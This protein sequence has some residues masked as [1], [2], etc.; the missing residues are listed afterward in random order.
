MVQ[1]RFRGHACNVFIINMFVSGPSCGYSGSG[2]LDT[3]EL[4]PKMN[5]EL[6][7]KS[8]RDGSMPLSK[9]YAIKK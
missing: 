2:E 6:D 5:R 4:E 3:A 9:Y 1:V 7:F 8:C